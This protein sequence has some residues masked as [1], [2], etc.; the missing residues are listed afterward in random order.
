MSLTIS[1]F[2]ARLKQKR[3]ARHERK[4]QKL[5]RRDEERRTDSL[6][7]IALKRPSSTTSFTAADPGMYYRKREGDELWSKHEAGGNKLARGG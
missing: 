7:R 5:Q 4:R 3:D 1:E 6:L 2:L